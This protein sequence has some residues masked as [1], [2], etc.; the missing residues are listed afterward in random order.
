MQWFKNF[1]HWAVSLL[2]AV[3]LCVAVV[4]LPMLTGCDFYG[5]C[6]GPTQ[7]AALP[8]ALAGNGEGK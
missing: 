8:H 6:P 5:Q 1:V 2:A 4:N 7:Q 3:G